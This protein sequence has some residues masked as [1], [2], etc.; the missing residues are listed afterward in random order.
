VGLGGKISI[1]L[2]TFFSFSQA[3]YF[4]MEVKPNSSILPYHL[5]TKKIPK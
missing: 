3:I 1:F 4:F 2:V 5:K